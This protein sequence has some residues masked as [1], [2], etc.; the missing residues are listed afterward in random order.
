MSDMNPSTF[1]K[2][3]KY[4]A[5]ESF[6]ANKDISSEVRIIRNIFY[7]MIVGAGQRGDCERRQEEAGS[8]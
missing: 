7:F 5:I 4:N 2:F 3:A 8:E 6:L 1:E